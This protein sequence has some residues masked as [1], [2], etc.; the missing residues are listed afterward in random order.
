MEFFSDK[1]PMDLRRRREI[2]GKKGKIIK[3]KEKK[4][5]VTN[6]ATKG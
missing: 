3:G 1:V 6:L 2:K 5:F 4:R